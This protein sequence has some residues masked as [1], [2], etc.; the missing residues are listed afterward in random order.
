MEE[1]IEEAKWLESCG[2]K[3]LNVIAQDTTAYGI[4]LYGKYA[5]VDLIKALTSETTIAKFRLLYC[6]PDKI[7]DE[8]IEE[9]KG[10]A[11]TPFGVPVLFICSCSCC[12][13]RCSYRH[14]DSRCR[15]PPSSVLRKYIPLPCPQSGQPQ[16]QSERWSFPASFL[17]SLPS[18]PPW[19]LRCGRAGR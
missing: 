12:S 2:V 14:W 15:L 18:Q 4:D 1:L 7:T 6:Y 13:C 3:E 17:I 19:H 16:Q 8:L 11:G 5:L 9:F 10:N